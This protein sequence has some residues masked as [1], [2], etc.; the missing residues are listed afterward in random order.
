MFIFAVIFISGTA[1]SQSTGEK[2]DGHST[3]YGEMDGKF[4]E[5][6]LN[7]CAPCESAL[8]DALGW[9]RCQETIG[10]KEVASLD[11]AIGG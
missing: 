5:F 6:K 4:W 9:C 10:R 8:R 2:P 11:D 7:R 3:Y 1:N